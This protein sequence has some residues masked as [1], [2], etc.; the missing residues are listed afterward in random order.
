VPH[1]I[2]PEQYR[3][4]GQLFDESFKRF[5]ARPFSVCMERWMTCGELDVLSQAMGAWLQSRGLAAGARVAIMLPNVPQFPV[6]MCGVLRA[7]YTCVNVN[8][9][10]ISGHR[11]RHFRLIVDAISA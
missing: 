5:A 4:L 6:T 7:G 8:P 10:R 1:K 3:N 2:H 9:L 11:G